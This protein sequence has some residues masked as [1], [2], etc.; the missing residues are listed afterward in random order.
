MLDY[1]LPSSYA[2]NVGLRDDDV[3]H[4]KHVPVG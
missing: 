1:S 3:D 4:A 2:C